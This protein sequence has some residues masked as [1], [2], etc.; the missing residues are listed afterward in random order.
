MG[1]DLAVSAGKSAPA[2]GSNFWLWVSDHDVNWWVAVATF[3]YIG[4]QIYY[5]VRSKGGGATVGQ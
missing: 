4:V 2:V 5:L 1:K 3:V